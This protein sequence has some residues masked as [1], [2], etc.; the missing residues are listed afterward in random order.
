LLHEVE[1][2]STLRNKVLQLA[3]RKCVAR[4]VGRTVV[5]R[6]TLLCNLQRNKVAR[7]VARFCCPYYRTLNKLETGVFIS[8][9]FG[10][11]SDL[12]FVKRFWSI[13]G[14]GAI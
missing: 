5:I 7:Q 2:A 11:M 3:T 1:R 13:L 8:V 12:I 6:E 9:S 14:K 10:K 4:Q